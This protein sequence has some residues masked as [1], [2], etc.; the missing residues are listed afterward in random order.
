MDEKPRKPTFSA[1]VRGTDPFL[2]AEDTNPLLE[3]FAVRRPRLTD[4]VMEWFGV[5]GW[6]IV[7]WLVCCMVAIYAQMSGA[8]TAYYVQQKKYDNTAP[9]RLSDIFSHRG[10][11]MQPFEDLW[12]TPVTGWEVAEALYV[13]RRRRQLKLLNLGFI[14]L[15]LTALSQALAL[16]MIFTESNLGSYGLVELMALGPLFIGLI[17]AA[18]IANILSYREM[19][20]LFWVVGMESARWGAVERRFDFLKHGETNVDSVGLTGGIVR[21]AVW[22]GIYMLIFAVSCALSALPTLVAQALLGLLLRG[23]FAG[24]PLTAMIMQAGG[25][26][27]QGIAMALIYFAARKILH[28]IAVDNIR[29]TFRECDWRYTQLGD[30]LLDP[31]ALP[32]TALDPA[33]RTA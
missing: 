19:L 4:Y 10:V 18:A 32:R 6:L 11:Q 15:Y 27:V 31:H 2:A 9:R 5:L 1:W 20:L 22:F 12:R 21:M 29:S 17:V 3:A 23:A 16:L 14:A 25:A 26:I 7:P 8:L 30:R 28:P 33:P 13:E 24:A